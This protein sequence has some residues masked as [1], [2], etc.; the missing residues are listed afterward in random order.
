MQGRR[1][2]DKKA[3]RGMLHAQ[4]PPCICSSVVA[5]HAAKQR[6]LMRQLSSTSRLQDLRSLWIRGESRECRCSMPIAVSRA[7]HRGNC[8]DE[9]LI[10]GV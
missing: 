1:V 10:E 9:S 6:A 8:T 7:W 4:P 2:L 5:Q 3:K